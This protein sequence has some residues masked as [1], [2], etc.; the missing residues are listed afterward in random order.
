MHDCYVAGV[1]A[2]SVLLVFP[3]ASSSDKVPGL[4]IIGTIAAALMTNQGRADSNAAPT[5]LA[6]TRM[7]VV[8]EWMTVRASGTGRG[9]A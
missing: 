5:V 3:P 4:R 1:Q 6:S 8:P 2:Q 7:V 9:C